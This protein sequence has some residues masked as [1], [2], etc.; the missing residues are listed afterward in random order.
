M[1]ERTIFGTKVVL[2][3]CGYLFLFATAIWDPANIITF[4]GRSE[5]NYDDGARAASFALVAALAIAI[6]RIPTDEV[7]WH[8]HLDF[9]IWLL[10]TSA[11]FLAAWWWLSDETN[12]NPKPYLEEVLIIGGVIAVAGLVSIGG[13]AVIGSVLGKWDRRGQP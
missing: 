7:Q 10:G 2:T 9:L 6:Q 11:A 8:K 3:I 13:G 12:G 5:S 1:R 4:T